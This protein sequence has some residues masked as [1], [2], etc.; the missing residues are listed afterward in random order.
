[1][2]NDGDIVY[3]IGVE[4]ESYKLDYETPY[5]IIKKWVIFTIIFISL[6]VIKQYYL[7]K[8]TLF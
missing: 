7:M 6:M 8:K 1:M 4:S 5:K 3:Y 2:F